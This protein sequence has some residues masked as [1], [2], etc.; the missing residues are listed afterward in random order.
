MRSS[1]TPCVAQINEFQLWQ[2]LLHSD[3]VPTLGL[4]VL[5]TMS[6]ATLLAFRSHLCR[7]IP[8]L[9]SLSLPRWSSRRSTCLLHSTTTTPTSPTSPTSSPTPT[10]SCS[11]ASPDARLMHWV[12]H[13]SSVT[14]AVMSALVRLRC[15]FCRRSKDA[16]RAAFL[17]L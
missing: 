12:S 11:S 6:T 2:G 7:D 10:C 1:K 14:I 17:L 16:K 15:K 5:D 9:T 4:L 3:D 13:C 8:H